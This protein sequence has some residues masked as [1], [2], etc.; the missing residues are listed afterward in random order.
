MK[1]FAWAEP[2]LAPAASERQCVGGLGWEAMGRR[3]VPRQVT[4]IS[5]NHTFAT[6]HASR[7]PPTPPNLF[8]LQSQP[9][10]SRKSG[11]PPSKAGRRRCGQCLQCHRKG[12]P[13]QARAPPRRHP[14]SIPTAEGSGWAVSSLRGQ[15]VEEE[16]RRLTHAAPME[17]KAGRRGAHG[18]PTPRELL[19]T[20]SGWARGPGGRPRPQSWLIG[21]CDSGPVTQHV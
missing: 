20:P 13:D 19:S 11:L 10:S 3:R 18:T 16:G 14:T 7:P 8:E 12:S 5:H 1:S 6:S 4:P 21:L 2:G 17:L 9:A 15:E